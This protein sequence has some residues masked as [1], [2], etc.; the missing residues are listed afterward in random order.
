MV[1]IIVTI[2]VVIMAAVGFYTYKLFSFNETVITERKQLKHQKINL[3]QS[4]EKAQFD[5]ERIQ[6]VQTDIERYRMEQEKLIQTQ[7]EFLNLRE[8]K[9]AQ[10]EDELQ[11]RIAQFENEKMAFFQRLQGKEY[12]LNT[13]LTLLEK[14]YK[15]VADST[16]QIRQHQQE[17]NDHHFI[18]DKQ[19]EKL[20]SFF[21]TTEQLMENLE[22]EQLLLLKEKN[23]LESAKNDFITKRQELSN[24]EEN[25]KSQLS[26]I[27]ENQLEIEHQQSLLHQQK[28]LFDKEKSD[29]QNRLCEFD[30]NKLTLDERQEKLQKE[31]KEMALERSRLLKR[32]N[33][34]EAREKELDESARKLE[35]WGQELVDKE[36]DLKKWENQIQEK[37]REFENLNKKD[38]IAEEK[39][40]K[41]EIKTAF[42]KL[43][44]E[45]SDDLDENDSTD[46]DDNEA[47]RNENIDDKTDKNPKGLA[48]IR[49]I[50][51]SGGV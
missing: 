44:A 41:S 33:E 3:K 38:D 43:A 28:E 6:K 13:G 32:I 36:R 18:I 25:L 37:A 27:E 21:D 24:Y 10:K 15:M 39:N 2:A 12:C 26:K 45:E 11:I 5:N 50:K 47:L 49:L 4:I 40:L 29:I 20:T 1:W 19:I 23:L 30:N 35:N 46:Y 34:L 48:G 31:F 51:G 42:N 14:K 7:I 8:Q 17:L 9:I 22:F 16:R